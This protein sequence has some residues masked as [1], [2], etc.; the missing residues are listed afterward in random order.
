MRRMVVELNF[1][2]VKVIDDDDDFEL[3]V[4]E[5]RGKYKQKQILLNELLVL[6]HVIQ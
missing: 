5:T 3:I 6:I 1:Q 2:E 4:G